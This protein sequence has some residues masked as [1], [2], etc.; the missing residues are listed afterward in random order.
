MPVITAT[1]E[2]DAGESL[3][4]GRQRLQQGLSLSTRVE[5]S[6]MNMAH[7]SLS[8]LGVSNLPNLNLPNSWDY[9]CEPP[10]AANFLYFFFFR[11]GFG[12]LLRL[13]SNS[14]AQAISSIWLFKHFGKPRWADH[15]RS[16]VRDQPG[17]H[18]ETPFLLKIQ[19]LAGCNGTC[20]CYFP[21]SLPVI[22]FPLKQNDFD[23]SICSHYFRISTSALTLFNMT[24]H[25][26]SHDKNIQRR[27]LTMLPR[28]AVGQWVFTGMIIAHYSLKR[29]SCLS[30]PR[31]WDYRHGDV[32]VKIKK[33]GAPA[34]G[35]PAVVRGKSRLLAAGNPV[36][37]KTKKS[38]RGGGACSPVSGAEA[39]RRRGG[40]G[41]APPPAWHG[42]SLLLPRLECNGTIL[43][44]C[45]IRLPGSSDSPAS[46]SQVAG[47]T[48]TPHHAW[49]IF[50]FLIEAGF[51]YVGQTSL[52]LLPQHLKKKIYIGQAGW[53]TPVIPA[54]WEAEV[55]GSPEVRSSRPAWPTW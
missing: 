42:F 35:R 49:L 29:S 41:G 47:T 21:T 18:G 3:E 16:G 53:L 8:L 34:F 15:L 43:A 2:A 28:L 52:E 4:P 48:G 9:R 14:E 51:H 31:S 10:C 38:R 17:Q 33:R 44:H 7:C 24:A 20:L 19:R 54:L 32:V 6:S 26:R 30:L 5:C 23:W 36:S 22:S 55:G 45:N 13:V 40:A 12:M 27:G 1:Q 46:A 25:A 39:V 50:L 11:Q 37:T